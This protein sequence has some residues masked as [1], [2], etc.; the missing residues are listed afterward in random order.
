MCTCFQCL[1]ELSKE[2]VI[3]LVW[4]LALGDCALNHNGVLFK[5]AQLQPN[6]THYNKFALTS[7]Q[8]Q[9]IYLPSIPTRVIVESVS[10]CW[11]SSR[12]LVIR[13][14]LLVTSWS[15]GL[16]WRRRKDGNEIWIIDFTWRHLVYCITKEYEANTQ[17][18]SQKVWVRNPN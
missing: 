9:T 7:S 17:R 3:C 14:S 11:V 5:R 6:N 8:I 10:Y 18:I 2:G 12:G 16:E 4:G 15:W 13:P 1:K